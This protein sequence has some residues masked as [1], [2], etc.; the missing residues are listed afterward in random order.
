MTIG[1]NSSYVLEHPFTK[2]AVE[3]YLAGNPKDLKFLLDI[4]Q[5]D[6]YQ[7][8]SVLCTKAFKSNKK[9]K[10]PQIEQ[11]IREVAPPERLS[12]KLPIPQPKPV[13]KVVPMK[14]KRH[15]VK[16]I[17]IGQLEILFPQKNHPL[18]V[19]L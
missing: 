2:R 16:I 3:N 14:V 15:R 5:I 17:L 10:F 7:E 11:A 19:A 18:Q 8:V 12:I 6:I 9:E 4:L 13:C 1:Q